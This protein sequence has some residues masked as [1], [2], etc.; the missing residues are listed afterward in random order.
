MFI[1]LSCIYLQTFAR[2][3]EYCGFLSRLELAHLIFVRS[4][5]FRAFMSRHSCAYQFFLRFCPDIRAFPRFLCL[6]IQTSCD[7]QNIERSCPDFS[8]FTR[9]LCVF[10]QTSG[11]SPDFRSFMFRLF[12]VNQTF[13]RLFA[14]LP[15]C[16]FEKWKFVC[17]RAFPFDLK[18]WQKD[19]VLKVF[20]KLY[21]KRVDEC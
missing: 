14:C 17:S 6:Y 21:K 20:L 11:R 5:V 4:P 15:I 18:I 1:R 3:P 8:S 16:S 12:C 19:D 7:H 13:V 10:V 2:S 9:F